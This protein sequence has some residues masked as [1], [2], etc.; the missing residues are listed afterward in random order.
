MKHEL[1][2]INNKVIC[3]SCG[4]VFAIFDIEDDCQLAPPALGVSVSEGV[5]TKDEVK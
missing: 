2:I 5:D 3:Q 1:V 4:R